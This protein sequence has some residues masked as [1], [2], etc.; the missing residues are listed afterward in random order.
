MTD[1]G[2]SKKIFKSSELEAKIFKAAFSG[3]SKNYSADCHFWKIEEKFRLICKFNQRI[4]ESKIKLNKST[5][6]YN[7]YKLTVLSEN[8]LSITQ[9]NSSI[10]F[11]YSDKQTININEETTEFKLVFKNE[12][13]NK[14]PLILYKDNNMMQNIYL[15]CTEETNKIEC[16]IRKDR[17]VEIMSRSGEKFF[18]S[19][20]VK[21]EGI[22]TFDNVLDIIIN[23]ENVV[24]K[25]IN[26]NI[27]KLLTHKVDKNSFIILE[28]ETDID[29][30]PIITTDYFSINTNKNDDMK[31]LFKKISNQKD[32][33]LLLLCQANSP[34]EY[35]LDINEKNLNN[36]NIL[37]SFKISKNTISEP[38]TVSEQEGTK[39][40]SVYPNSLN[41]TT[42]DKLTINYQ[43]ENPEKLKN[44]KLNKDSTSYLEC[45]NK[46]GMKECIV[47]QSHFNQSGNYYTYYTNSLG[48]EV[49]S[50]EIPKIQIN[51]Q[52]S[53]GGQDKKGGEEKSGI[54]KSN[55]IGIIVGSVGGGLALIAIIVII[56]IFAKKK[57]N[58]SI[59]V[60]RVGNI[61][62]KSAEVEL[63][64]G[65]K[66]E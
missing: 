61:L 27:T 20:L 30:I 22:L 36:L 26:I 39:I 17:L 56:V 23:Y 28:T 48:D 16:F 31:C 40:I 44:I 10:S 53:D 18:L 4:D 13:Y 65:D 66:F 5:L 52:K 41:L 59:D 42:L 11:L 64:E 54:S 57:K 55:L 6:S 32:D 62:P 33:K 47:T 9:L 58:N 60:N 19:Q 14:E 25:N 3:N 1:F 46:I 50:Y 29:N 38:V 24:K 35:K 8:D 15:T 63:I 2:D 49:I 12:Q 37:Y 7:D 21:S 45:N 43:T 51:I 34:G